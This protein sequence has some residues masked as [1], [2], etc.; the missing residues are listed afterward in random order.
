MP[1]ALSPPPIIATTI[2]MRSRSGAITGGL[3]TGIG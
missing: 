2:I 3:T 1:D